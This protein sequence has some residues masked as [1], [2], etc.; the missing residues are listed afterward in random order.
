MLHLCNSLF[1]V[2]VLTQ[3]TIA[4][5]LWVIAFVWKKYATSSWVMRDLTFWVFGNHAITPSEIATRISLGGL[6][7]V[8]VFF[9]MQS[10]HYFYSLQ[11][12][13]NGFKTIPGTGWSVDLVMVIIA[14][15]NLAANNGKRCQSNWWV[16]L[17]I[18][19]NPGVIILVICFLPRLIEKER[20]V[21]HLNTICFWFMIILTELFFWLQLVAVWTQ[22]HCFLDGF[23]S[24]SNP[25]EIYVMVTIT[26]AD[27]LLVGFLLDTK[28]SIGIKIIFGLVAFYNT[29]ICIGLYILYVLIFVPRAEPAGIG[30]SSPKKLIK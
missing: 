21:D 4:F 8:R 1:L 28:D 26:M 13:E 16:S 20:N 6:T 7:G 22:T 14:L 25:T 19:I 3:A 2:P 11:T 18:L 27:V 23:V 15:S 5:G 12:F 24:T 9:A 29:V 17:I 30:T 10:E